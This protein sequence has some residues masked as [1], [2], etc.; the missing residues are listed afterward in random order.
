MMDSLA[1]GGK[2]VNKAPMCAVLLALCNV[3]GFAQT[4]FAQ[5]GTG[6]LM[7]HAKEK[8]AVHVP[9]QEPE[10][11]LKTIYSNLGS[12]KTDLYDDANG[13]A[14]LGPNNPHSNDQFVG[15]PFTPKANAHVSQVRV[16]VEY[17]SGANQVNLSIYE[18]SGGVP[19]TLLAGPVTVTDLPKLFTCCTLATANFTPV[20]VTKG[21][22]YWVVANTPLTGTGSDFNGGWST[23]VKPP[24]RLA[25]MSGENGSGMWFAQNADLLVAGEVLGSTP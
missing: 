18:D 25:V 4:G 15:M 19:G 12:S 22:Q 14:L 20:A 16:A 17:G 24:L 23:V 13:W 10:A 21:L 1:T 9:A 6:S 7:V 2:F 8:P 5:N 3:A 11:G